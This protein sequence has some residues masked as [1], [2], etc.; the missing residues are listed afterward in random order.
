MRAKQFDPDTQSANGRAPSNLFALARA[1]Y[2]LQCVQFK[3]RGI[4]Q[5]DIYIRLLRSLTH[6][7]YHY[8]MRIY[9][10]I[11]CAVCAGT[12]LLPLGAKRCEPWLDRYIYFNPLDHQTHHLGQPGSSCIN[13]KRLRH[14][15]IISLVLLLMR[16]CK[17]II[18][19]YIIDFDVAD[20]FE[21]I[22]L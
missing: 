8:Y 7:F 3:M 14:S 5:R 10:Y 11:C 9:I 1:R 19:S 18:K 16:S 4:A 21:I 17:M 15:H 12:R 22:T 6:S 20:H 13:A 2:P